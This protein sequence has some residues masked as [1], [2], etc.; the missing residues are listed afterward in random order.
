VC[1]RTA[2]T[3]A[4]HVDSW[5]SGGWFALSLS[6][7]YDKSYGYN[8]NTVTDFGKLNIEQQGN[9]VMDFFDAAQAGNCAKVKKYE[10]VLKPYLPALQIPKACR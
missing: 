5:T 2:S 3:T 6:G 8:I 4:A 9:V 10:A 1:G 7:N